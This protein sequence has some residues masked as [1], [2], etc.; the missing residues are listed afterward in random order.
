MCVCVRVCLGGYG[1]SSSRRFAR[2]YIYVC[3]CAFVCCVCQDEEKG[4]CVMLCCCVLAPL[5]SISTHHLYILFFCSILIPLPTS[6][7]LSISFFHEKVS[8]SLCV[9]CDVCVCVL[10]RKKRRSMERKKAKR[11]G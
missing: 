4:A 9:S 3:L 6:P 11:E 8:L 2:A 5:T 10:S 7:T 1:C